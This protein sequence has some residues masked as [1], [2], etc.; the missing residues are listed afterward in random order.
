MQDSRTA[1]EIAYDATRLSPLPDDEIAL[2]QEVNC[3]IAQQAGGAATY[4][5]ERALEIAIEDIRL[6]PEEDRA[7][8]ILDQWANGKISTAAYVDHLVASTPAKPSRD[9]AH[10]AERWEAITD[11]IATLDEAEQA[12]IVLILEELERRFD[13]RRGSHTAPLG[14][15]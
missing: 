3:L 4:Q 8:T 14:G 2:A 7:L 13:D 12:E 6:S 15:A 5:A 10:R 1:A 9:E 11:E